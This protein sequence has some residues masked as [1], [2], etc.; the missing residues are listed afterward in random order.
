MWYQMDVLAETSDGNNK[1][2]LI[3]RARVYEEKIK[4]AFRYFRENGVEP[5][6]IKGWAAA[7]EYPQK[8]E[9]FFGD[10]DLCVAPVDFERSYSLVEAEE[11]R[12][13]N[14]DLHC[15][16]RHLDTLV[17]KDL[18]ENSI[19]IKLDGEEIR[20]LRPEDHL[21]VLCVHWLTDGG[22]EKEKLLDILHI[23]NNHRKD[24]DWERCFGK[25]SGTR[26]DWIIKTIGAIKKYYDFDDS[27]LPFE[28]AVDRLPGWF[29]K[30]LEDE[31]V[32]E[33]KSVPVHLTLRNFA[34]FRKQ[35]K[36]RFPPNPIQATVDME[37]K[38]DDTPRFYYQIGSF[39][40]R[41]KP[42]VKRIAKALRVYS[43]ARKEK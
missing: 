12:K 41:L 2:W 24:F 36:K 14:I 11:G 21:R 32:S 3:L 8:Y 27:D 17:W 33:T 42:S 9:R 37:G 6:L 7:I 13:L 26:R 34:E 39:L 38:F 18:F 31:W 23:L 5:I 4:A 25:I 16:L 29:T 30:A 22:G 19:L 43:R 20:V 15:G 35:L 1:R 10:I 40:K 28:L